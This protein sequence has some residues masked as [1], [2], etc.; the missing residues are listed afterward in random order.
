MPVH[1]PAELAKH[2]AEHA[3]FEVQVAN[4]DPDDALPITADDILDAHARIAEAAAHVTADV[5]VPAFVPYFRD[6]GE[7]M[8]IPLGIANPDHLRRG[9][10]YAAAEIAALRQEMAEVTLRA[11]GYHR[12]LTAEED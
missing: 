10:V 12:I 4:T 11:I 1:D 9:L 3:C 2:V 7:E 5:P 6:D 8:V